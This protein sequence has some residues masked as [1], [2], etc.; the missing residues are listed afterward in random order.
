MFKNNQKSSKRSEVPGSRGLFTKLDNPIHRY[1]NDLHFTAEKT[2]A[3]PSPHSERKGGV[4]FE[5]KPRIAS[6]RYECKGKER[7][8]QN[9]TMSSCGDVLP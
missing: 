1:Q 2:E 7:S 4:G 3:C 9:Q 8:N 5:L 6:Q